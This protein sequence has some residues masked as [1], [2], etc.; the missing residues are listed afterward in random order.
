[1]SKFSYVLS[2]VFLLLFQI[3]IVN[4]VSLWGMVIPMIYILFILILPFQMPRWLVVFL[5]FFMGFTVD[6]FTGILGLHAAALGLMAFLRM[7]I[8][9]I[10][11]SHITFEEHLRPILWDMR[12]AWY[13]Q[14]VLYLTLIHHIAYFYL[15]V[16]SLH[17][18]ML[19]LGITLLNVVFTVLLIFLFQ[20]IFFK[21]SKRY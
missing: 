1:M 7:P 6:I 20:I 3:L 21:A 14:Y 15:E 18:F 4:N 17:N 9:N 16:M 13:F 10:I 12:F 19:I 2:F 5:G 8:I 11:P